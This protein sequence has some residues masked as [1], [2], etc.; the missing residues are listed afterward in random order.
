M[1]FFN[2]KIVTKSIS[3]EDAVKKAQEPKKPVRTLEEILADTAKLN[4]IAASQAE[5]KTAAVA[6]APKAAEV[7]PEEKK[8]ENAAQVKIA[9]DMGTPA[10]SPTARPAIPGKPP[11]PAPGLKAPMAPGLKAPMAPAP[12]P[13]AKAPVAP[14]ASPLPGQAPAASAPTIPQKLPGQ[15]PRGIRPPAAKP[16]MPAPAGSKPSIA[17]TKPQMSPASPAAPSMSP[18]AAPAMASSKKSLKIA[19]SLDFRG[20]EAQAVAD[21]WKGHGSIEACVQ[22]VGDKASDAQTY[23]SLLRVAATEADKVIKAAASKAEVKTAAPVYKKIAK[24]TGPE[25]SF[26]REFFSKIYG[27]DYVKALLADY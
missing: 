15:A 2:Q 22:N 13:M 14:A 19:S 8:A 25:Q 27:E 7:K 20:W 23:C 1:N 18:S 21:A 5:V 26:L 24:L 17:P 4:K 9:L 11:I 16:P 6:E 12:A 3:L 10:P